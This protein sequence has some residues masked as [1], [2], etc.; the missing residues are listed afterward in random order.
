FE[1]ARDLAKGRVWVGQ[2]AYEN[3]LVDSLGGLWTA[4]E[5]TK[6]YLNIP[7]DERV[8]IHFYPEPEDLFAAL[9]KWL[10][11]RMSNSQTIEKRLAF[12]SLPQLW[13]LLRPAERAQLT[14]LLQL[15][16]MSRKESTL[17]ALPFSLSLDQ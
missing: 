12:A 4:I 2:D 3:S 9:R 10:P 5:F 14:Y 16:V 11:L 13:M 8:R 15:A 17:M 7:A 1:Q 6:D